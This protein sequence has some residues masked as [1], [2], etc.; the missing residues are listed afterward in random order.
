MTNPFFRK[1]L[2][3]D[4]SLTEAEARA[5]DEAVSHR[6]EV[7]ADVEL[8]R[9]DEISHQ[10]LLLEQ[11]WA[12]RYGAL[13][14]G[15]R[16]ILALH[17]SGDFVDLQSFPL[18][19]MDHTVATLS[20]CR[21]AV[22]P[23]ENL[24]RLSETMPHLTRL[25]WMATLIDAAILRQWLLGAGQRSAL[26][27]AAHLIC[28]LFTRLDVVGA[29]PDGVFNLPLTQAELG[30]ALGVS[31]VHANRVVGE[32][33]SRGLV[34]WRDETVRI[35]DWPGLQALAEFDPTYLMLESMDR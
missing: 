17:V 20:R 11:G 24:R 3:R 31:Q 19:R 18:K 32:L 28:E 13:P 29:A 7:D 35:L 6:I 30:D 4:R 2:R 25:L 26:E 10:S 23:H 22:Y 9:Q 34:T 5:L 21:I 33:R 14:D 1:L 15:R 8:V 27:R 12:C 16:Q